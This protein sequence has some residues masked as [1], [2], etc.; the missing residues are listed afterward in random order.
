MIS[1]GG[2]GRRGQSDPV[3]NPGEVLAGRYRIVRFIAQGGMGEVYEAE[4]TELLQAVALKTV[5]AS[6][7]DEPAAVERF[8]REIALARRVTHPN[9]C[10]IFDLGQHQASGVEAPVTFLSMELLT[11]ETLSACLRRRGRLSTEEALP[12]VRQMADALAAAHGAHVVHRDFKSENVYLVP[13]NGHDLSDLR[14]A[15]VV[16]T[17][18]GIARASDASDA[19]AAQVTG[20]GIVGTP[21]YMAPEQVENAPEIT[22]AAD[23]YALGIVIYEMVTGALPFDGGN[24]L[25]TAVKRLQ[26]APPPPHVHVPDLPA[27][28]ERTILRCLERRPKDRFERVV[29]VPSSLEAPTR[30]GLSGTVAGD[31]KTAFVDRP[32]PG[33]VT[34]P[35]PTGSTPTMTPPQPAAAPAQDQP[36]PRRTW[37]LAAVLVVVAVISGALAWL[38]RDDELDP[39]RVQLRRSVAVLGF[40]NLSGREDADWLATALGEMFAAEVAQ[41]DS[42]R[43][44]GGEQ[45][46]ATRRQL[47]E[48]WKLGELGAPLLGQIRGLLDCDFAIAGSY[49]SLG[50]DGDLRVDVRLHDAALGQQIASFSEQGPSD[51]LFAMV[52]RLGDQLGETLGANATEGELSGLPRDAEAARLYA[53]GLD[54][55]REFRPEAARQALER[56]I[57][58]DPENPLLHS[59]L[60]SAWDALGF[61]EK[62]RLSAARAFELSSGLGP[63]DR[64][65]I[66]ARHRQSEGDWSTAYEVYRELWQSFPDNLDY[67]LGLAT[68]STGA[69]DP[70]SALETLDQLRLLP[71]PLG[72][73]ARIDL[74]EAAAAGL[75]ALLDRQEAAASRAVTKAEAEGATLPLARALVSRAQALRALGRAVPSEQA[76]SRARG[77]FESLRQ[78]PGVAEATSAIASSYF[79]Q[80]RFEEAVEGYLEAADIY[81]ELGDRGGVASTLN[82]LAVVRKRLG[83]FSRAGELYRETE[84]IYE[85]VADRRGLAVARNNQAVLL[86]DRDQL[87]EAEAI[88]KDSLA[89]WEE[90]GGQV[91]RAYALNNLAEVERLLGRLD[92]SL[93]RHGEALRIRQSAQLTA[94]E[95]V[96][97]TNLAGVLLARGE[98]DAA[99]AELDAAAALIGPQSTPTL[100]SLHAFRRGE[101]ALYSGRVAEALERHREALEI[102]E[103]AGLGVELQASQL[104]L[105]RASSEEGDLL[106]AESLAEAVRSQSQLEERPA[107][108]L[109]AT[110]LLIEIYT[111]TD[112]LDDAAG[113]VEE[114]T[115]LAATVQQPESILRFEIS[116]ATG[117]ESLTAI[118]AEARRLQLA[119][120]ELHAL[121]AAVVLAEDGQ[122][123]GAA[124]LRRELEEIAGDRGL[125]LF[126][127]AP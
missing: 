30:P 75:A 92:S 111:A 65:L 56:A 94:D 60:A 116:T 119:L 115:P 3:F 44:V 11:G 54:D 112:R 78:P 77:L 67:G 124:E 19:F 14:E 6:I 105:A 53:E 83:D 126:S 26:E 63:E 93:E 37:M 16:V 89:V 45:V 79:D 123:P 12:L 102:R 82:N 46:S 99:A 27:W 76:A 43:S 88:F 95:A 32:E 66:E 87:A 97:R 7:G 108:E 72:E 120:V 91:G 40:E 100:R 29:D 113:L 73:D 103:A 118:R 1:T 71:E 59:A 107:D 70:R 15:R 114:A 9:V 10:R 42:L 64:L 21:A 49:V 125:G 38:N 28:W 50:A 22:E 58:R 122:Q 2:H 104:A 35:G 69:G 81:R 86:V 98:P 17:D 5:S 74:A 61:D 80:G 31:A 127:A 55:L 51:E 57:V 41:T 47:G 34:G 85:E 84:A 62:S 52:D 96:S 109:A 23:I 4:D 48:E 36:S 33:G 110:A 24:P 18:F 25:T 68:A 101:V 90:A 20:L 39:T 8:K 13:Q 121:R 117:V 106:E